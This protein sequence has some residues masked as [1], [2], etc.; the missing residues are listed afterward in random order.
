MPARTLAIASCARL[1]R[2]VAGS[3]TDGPHSISPVASASVYRT[4]VRSRRCAPDQISGVLRI[5]ISWI[6]R[7]HRREEKTAHDQPRPRRVR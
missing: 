1:D 3:R 5:A 7:G 2:H 4:Y 6:R